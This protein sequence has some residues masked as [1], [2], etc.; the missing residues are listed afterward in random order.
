MS[1]SIQLRQDRAA[2]V[3]EMRTVC[4]SKNPADAARWKEL[5]VKQEALRSQIQAAETTTL[6][7]EMTTIRNADRP[8]FDSRETNPIGVSENR[9]AWPANIRAADSPEYR[10]VFDSFVRHGENMREIRALGAVSADNGY[11]L[12]P[13]GFQ[14]EVANYAKAIG[15]LRQCARVVT[16]PTGQPLNWPRAQDTSNKGHWLPESN[17]IQETD[18]VFDNVT[19]GADL[20]SSDSVLVPVE[21]M[22]DSAFSVE[23][24]LAEQFGI[25]LARGTAAA[26]MNGNGLGTTGLLPQLIAAAVSG[27]AI[28][29]IGANSNSG[30]SGDTDLNTIGTDDLSNLIEQV[31]PAYRV[32]PNVGFLANQKTWDTIRKVKDKYGRALWDVSLASGTPDKILGYPYWYDQSMPTIAAGAVGTI[33]FGDFSKYIIRDVLGMTMVRYNEL[34]MTSHQIGFEAFLRTTGQLL[35]APAFSYLVT[36]QS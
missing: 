24:L 28:E 13:V 6:E 2:I 12:V 32:G 16:T 3:A 25:R 31:D 20:L 15:G 27:A 5:D 7:A 33:I 29:A 19:L 9:A 1:S 21:L 34:Y 23:A 11:T 17:A 8:Y 14:K 10:K 18:P 26:Y 36:S 30:N 4:N 35:I 22:Q